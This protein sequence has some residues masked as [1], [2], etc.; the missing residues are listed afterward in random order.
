MAYGKKA[1]VTGGKWD[2]AKRIEI[3]R[4]KLV[5]TGDVFFGQLQGR[6]EV[7]WEDAR[8]PKDSEKRTVITVWQFTAED[9]VN[10][11]LAGD[12]TLNS[13]LATVPVGYHVRIQRL[14]QITKGA[15]K[16][17][18]YDIRAMRPNILLC[19]VLPQ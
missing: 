13:L 9:G 8:Q 11:D 1:T 18:Q 4:I 17:N 6:K 12:W 5:K 10:C 19:S 15:Q 7:P 2:K 16:M 3:R 14:E